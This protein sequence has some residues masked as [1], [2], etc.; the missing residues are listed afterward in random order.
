MI[1]KII[2]YCWFGNIPIPENFRKYIESWKKHCPDYEIIQWNE[3]NFNVQSCEFVRRAYKEKKWA[4]VSDYARLWI[5][6]NE[7]GFYLDTDVE[8]L[9]SLDA[10]RD[11]SVWFSCEGENVNT[12]LGFG[13]EQYNKVVRRNMEIYER[14]IFDGD[15]LTDIH[16][17][18][19]YTTEMLREFGYVSPVKGIMA[20][21]RGA[22]LD[23]SYCNPYDW[24]TKKTK[25]K[26][27]TISIHH[28]AATWLSDE[29]KRYTLEQ[30]NYHMIKAK[31][32]VR[33]ANIYS[34][35]F[36]SKKEN[37][38]EGVVKTITLRLRKMICRK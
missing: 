30:H 38:G 22:I 36:W 23:N 2:H 15:G 1:P 32:G 6:Y 24:A 37:G 28:Y 11:Y 17:C 31:Y 7:G 14:M 21:G 3:S 33:S 16:P 12:G 19:Y 8:L 25:I 4:F 27:H 18:P 34:Y 5:V 10:L 29:E 20:I 35:Y 26:R 13:A 9:K